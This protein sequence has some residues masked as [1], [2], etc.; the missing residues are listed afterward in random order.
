MRL[1]NGM[2]RGSGGATLRAG[3]DGVV[4]DVGRS[5]AEDDDEGN[6]GWEWSLG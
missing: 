6:P 3:D 5:V 4:H 2:N 1:W